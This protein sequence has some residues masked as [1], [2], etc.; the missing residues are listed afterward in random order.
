MACF[1]YL[2]LKKHFGAQKLTQKTFLNDGLGSKLMLTKSDLI[3]TLKSC[4]KTAKSIFQ[5]FISH[6]KNL[7]DSICPINNRWWFISIVWFDKLHTMY[8]CHLPTWF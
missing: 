1:L 8:S 6:G 2:L 7:K 4:M 5:S 3:V